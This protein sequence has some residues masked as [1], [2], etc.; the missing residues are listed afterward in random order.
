M[1]PSD[2]DRPAME[3]ITVSD[4]AHDTGKDPIIIK[5]FQTRKNTTGL[6]I[7]NYKFTLK[8]GALKKTDV[9]RCRVKNCGA[10]FSTY[11]EPKF[12]IIPNSEHPIH[13]HEPT[14]IAEPSTD[15]TT[16]LPPAIEPVI[17]IETRKMQNSTRLTVNR[18]FFKH[19]RSTKNT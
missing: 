19:H 1:I 18:I 9:W 11:K 16:N 14:N 10:T 6:L 3:Q 12:G 15:S 4:I 5:E 13:T 7:N 17:A 2:L 8:N